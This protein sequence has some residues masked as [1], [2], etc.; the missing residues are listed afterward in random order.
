MVSR[1]TV[2]N[3]NGAGGKRRQLATEVE[4]GYIYQGLGARL[5]PWMRF[6]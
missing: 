3:F 5:R 4:L 6:S 2:L 1:A